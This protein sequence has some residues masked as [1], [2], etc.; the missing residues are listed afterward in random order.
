MCFRGCRIQRRL[1]PWCRAVQYSCTLSL[2]I[3]TVYVYFTSVRSQF[4]SVPQWNSDLTVVPSRV[5]CSPNMIS[6]REGCVPCSRGTFSFPGWREC[7]PWLNCSEIA[8]Q[9]RPTR[10]FH[11]GITKLVW[12]AEWNGYHVV[13]INCSARDAGKRKRCSKGM[14][15]L[16][17]IQGQFVTPLI[18]RCP[19]KLQVRK[20]MTDGLSLDFLSKKA[21]VSLV[22][23]HAN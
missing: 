11:H 16:K 13:F 9:V 7:T 22:P 21:C 23:A 8:L 15:N 20:A 14:S 3:F 12:H 4:D 6:T 17:R 2:V 1:R 19:E 18:G 5:A 10:R